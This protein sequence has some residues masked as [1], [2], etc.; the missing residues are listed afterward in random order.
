MVY[1]DGEYE[2]TRESVHFI[3]TSEV[4]MKMGTCEFLVSCAVVR[5]LSFLS[6][7]FF[8]NKAQMS[9]AVMEKVYAFIH[10]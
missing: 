4:L 2:R 10:G 8:Y 6:F 9:I 7:F 3:V 1:T 5:F